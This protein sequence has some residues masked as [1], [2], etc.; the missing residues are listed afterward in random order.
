MPTGPSLDPGKMRSLQRVTTPDGYFVI[1]AHDHLSYFQ[2]L[3]NKD[4]STVDYARTGEAKIELIRA[5]APECSAFLP[6]AEFGLAQ[7]QVVRNLVEQ[8][9]DL[10]MS[11]VVE[12]IWYPL[13]GEDT[14]SAEWR[15]RRV[16]G[17]VAS[18]HEI[19]ALGVDMLKVEFPGYVETSEG[20]EAA[21]DACKALDAGIS[22]LPWVILSAGVGYDLFRVQ[23]EIACTAGA[24]GFLAGR[25]IW[26]DAAATHDPTA[27]QAAVRQASARLA[28]LAA[29]TRRCGRPYMPTLAGTALTDAFPPGWYRAWHR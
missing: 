27:R 24:S 19:A 9:A 6:D 29:I 28:E 23:V 17:I 12:P 16:E 10:S 14:K 8:C 22:G 11:L 21:L 13:I 26:R 4:P 18:A 1:C 3:L 25:S 15:E 7:R 20:R 2:E 5:L